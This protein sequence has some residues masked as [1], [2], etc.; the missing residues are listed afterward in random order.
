MESHYNVIMMSIS[1]AG[2]FIK[3]GQLKVKVS[4]LESRHPSLHMSCI[5]TFPLARRALMKCQTIIYSNLEFVHQ[6]PIM[7]AWTETV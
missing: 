2:D 4:V 5:L 7:A 3:H 6:V 1:C